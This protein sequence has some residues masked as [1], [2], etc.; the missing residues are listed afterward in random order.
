MDMQM[1]KL[2]GSRVWHII[3]D[4]GSD[5]YTRAFCGN[6]GIVLQNGRW[7]SD[8]WSGRQAG[9]NVN[10]AEIE[11]F[12]DNHKLCPSCVR[13]AYQGGLLTIAER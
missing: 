5:K 13:D 9:V 3:S 10:P 2:K 12:A 4:I 7:L 8:Y 6:S 11:P 1:Y